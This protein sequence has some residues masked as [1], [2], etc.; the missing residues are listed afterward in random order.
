MYCPSTWVAFVHVLCVYYIVWLLSMYCP[1]TWVAFVHVLCVYYIVWLLSM[2]CPST[3]VAIAHAH[4]WLCNA[5]WEFTQT[6]IN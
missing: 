4:V 6:L 5:S 1:S 2:Y 3:C